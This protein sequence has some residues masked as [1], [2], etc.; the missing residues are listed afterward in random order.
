MSEQVF[1]FKNRKEMNA[2]LTKAEEE[3][4]ATMLIYVDRYGNNGTIF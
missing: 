4:K 1:E 2:L 3:Q